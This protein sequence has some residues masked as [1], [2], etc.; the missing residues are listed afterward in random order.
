MQSEEYRAKVLKKAG[1][2]K[3]RTVRC[4]I[5]YISLDGDYGNEIPSVSATCGRCGYETESYGQ[6]EASILRCLVLMREDCPEGEENWYE[7]ELDD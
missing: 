2:A 3:S 1:E 5:D 7:E 6:S 4:S